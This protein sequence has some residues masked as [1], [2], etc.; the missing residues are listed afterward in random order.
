M[1]TLTDGGVTRAGRTDAVRGT[2]GFN[3]NVNLTMETRRGRVRISGSLAH[4]AVH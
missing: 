1:L 3:R 4:P 2:I